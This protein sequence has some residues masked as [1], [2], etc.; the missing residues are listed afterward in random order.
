VSVVETTQL[1]EPHGGKLVDRTGPR[2]DGLE[3]LEQLALTSR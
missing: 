1:I 3:K 2:P